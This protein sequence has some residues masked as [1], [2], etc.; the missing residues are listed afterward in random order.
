MEV[1]YPTKLSKYLS[2]LD[3]NNLYGWA[4]SGHLHNNG[5][6][7]LKNVKILIWFQSVETVQQDI[8]SKSI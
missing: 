4:M 1:D 8:F 5:F 6:K 7:R 3:M 2:Y